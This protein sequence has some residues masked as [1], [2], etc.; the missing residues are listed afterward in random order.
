MKKFLVFAVLM[1]SAPVLADEVVE[2]RDARAKSDVYIFNTAGEVQ[3][4]GWSRNEVEVAADLGSGVKELIFEVDD[5]DVTIEVKGSKKNSQKIASDL[6]IQVPEGSSVRINT[7]SADIEIEEVQGRQNL[8]TV[9]GDIETTVY[10]SDVE[11][12]TVSG[13]ID[14]EGSGKQVRARVNTVSG[15]IEVQDLGGEIEAGAV[16]GDIDIYEGGYE[17]VKMQTVNGDIEYRA[18]LNDDGHMNVETVNGDIDVEFV[19]KVSARFNIETFNGDIENCF[20]PAPKRT[21][22]YAP[23]RELKFTEGGGKGRVKI[24]T[25]NGSL[26]LCKE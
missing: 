9:S 17:A 6:M 18:G 2:T 20:G 12:E 19:G 22:K 3:V 1:F 8:N 24:H 13:D 10:E 4:Q 5:E 25:L 11:L 26:T 7:V 15:D 14:A 23:G 16:N 21:S